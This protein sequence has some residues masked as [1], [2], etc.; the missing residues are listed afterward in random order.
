MFDAEAAAMV[1]KGAGWRG[2]LGRWLALAGRGAAT[3]FF[4]LALGDPR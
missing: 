2:R 1:T 3:P 4:G